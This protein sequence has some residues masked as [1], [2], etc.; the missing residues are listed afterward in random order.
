LNT[1]LCASIIPRKKAAVKS[2]ICMEKDDF[3]GNP[4]RNKGGWAI[5]LHWIYIISC[6]R[7]VP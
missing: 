1:I 5:L 2:R 3:S 4:L 7:N 6:R